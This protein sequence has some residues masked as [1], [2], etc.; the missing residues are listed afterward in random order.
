MK[1]VS[2]DKLLTMGWCLKCH[3]DPDAAPAA[4]GRGDE[5]D[6]DADGGQ[7][8]SDDRRGDQEGPAGEAA[9]ELPGVPPVSDVAA[10]RRA[11]APESVQPHQPRATRSRSG[12]E[13][14]EATTAA[15]TTWRTRRSSGRS[16]RSS[17]A[18]PTCTNRLGEAE[19]ID[20]DP[21]A[22]GLNRR[23]FLALSA[24]R[25]RLAGSPAAAA[26][27]C[28]SCP[29]SAIPDDQIGHLAP[30]KPTFYATSIPRPGGAL[31]VLVE[32]HDGRPT[33]IEGNPQAPARASARPTPSRRRRCSTSTAPTA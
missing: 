21:D 5:P 15:S 17:P 2:H 10:S 23:K 22:A 8:A 12:D 29:F 25:S 18:S 3:N 26:R 33:K 9:D 32:S 24:A 31:P 27:T 14:I 30:G 28:R 19:P 11:F 20:D 16:R 4:G 13:R 7:T 6:V 1:V